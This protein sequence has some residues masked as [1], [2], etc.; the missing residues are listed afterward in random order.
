[1]HSDVALFAV[2][3]GA[4][5]YQPGAARRGRSGNGTKRKVL[6][7]G[8]IADVACGIIARRE[9]RRTRVWGMFRPYRQRREGFFALCPGR[10]TSA[11]FRAALYSNVI[12]RAYLGLAPWL[13]TA[14]PFGAESACPD[15]RNVR[16][17]PRHL[18]T[19][20]AQ[21]EGCGCRHSRLAVRSWNDPL[22]LPPR[23]ADNTLDTPTRFRRCLKTK[24]G[25]TMSRMTH[26]I[27]TV[28]A[29]LAICI[30]ASAGSVILYDNLKA[31]TDGQD[32]APP[33]SDGKR[34]A[35]SF[36]T[37][38]V[39]LTLQSVK[40]KLVLVGQPDFDQLKPIVI[41][42]YKDNGK[43]GVGD[44]IAD[45]GRFTEQTVK[46]DGPVIEADKIPFN[47]PLAANSRYWIVLTDI[48]PADAGNADHLLDL[49]QRY[50]G[51]R[52]RRRILCR[53]NRPVR[54]QRH[55]LRPVPDAS[56]RAER[57]RTLKPRPVWHGDLSNRHR[58]CPHSRSHAPA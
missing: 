40:V 23:Q 19:S 10:G 50:L 1:M 43:P 39:P 25:V 7:S 5:A 11:L 44:L 49:V 22:S 2:S 28:V 27:A 42:L 35:D 9:A 53:H 15:T 31:T 33:E 26:F 4:T 8:T 56:H 21:G 37:G 12:A 36:S 24:G 30:E 54:Q 38:K 20:P 13:L 48:A 47:Q 51:H 14:A 57:S 3:W 18:A 41:E 52:R 34:L 6:T 45:I 29:F 16:V 17:N 58:V 55:P 46:E 32:V